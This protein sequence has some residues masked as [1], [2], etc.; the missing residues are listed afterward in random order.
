MT[1]CKNICQVD[2]L[3]LDARVKRQS[4]RK[5]TLSYGDEQIN[6]GGI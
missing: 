6:F 1:Y 5:S 4:E 2:K 3:K